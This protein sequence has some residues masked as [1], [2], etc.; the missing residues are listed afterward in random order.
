MPRWDFHC[1][2]CQKTMELS[3]PHVIDTHT[4]TCPTCGKLL[5][6]LFPTTNFVLKGSGFHKN[7]YPSSR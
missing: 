7:D 5:V 2:E 6:R 3:F 1:A 4:A